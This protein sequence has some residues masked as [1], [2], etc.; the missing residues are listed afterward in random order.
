MIRGRTV[1]CLP[2]ISEQLGHLRK[3]TVSYSREIASW[4]GTVLFL[5]PRDPPADR[6]LRA[7]V[8]GGNCD[9]D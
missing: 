4:H 6:G 9:I 2:A 1:L 8:T 7:K 3:T 5:N